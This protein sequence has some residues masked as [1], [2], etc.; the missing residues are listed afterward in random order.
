MSILH[1]STL[2]HLIIIQ[3]VMNNQ[4]HY[5]EL[6]GNSAS[7]ALCSFMFHLR[8]NTVDLVKPLQQHISLCCQFATTVFTIWIV[9]RR[10]VQHLMCMDTLD[11]F[12][13]FQHLFP[14][15]FSYDMVDVCRHG[16]RVNRRREWHVHDVRLSSVCVNVFSGWHRVRSVVHWR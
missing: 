9:T 10:R 7:V 12:E 4:L 14:L 15:R 8:E 5:R 13:Y 1:P 16:S 6:N 3:F 2:V 11:A